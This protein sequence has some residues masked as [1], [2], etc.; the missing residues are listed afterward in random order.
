MANF[1]QH[2]LE[3]GD[4]TS[5][6]QTETFENSES[7]ATGLGVFI[8]KKE[9]DVLYWHNGAT[10]GFN[11]CIIYEPI[12]KSGIVVLTNR[13]LGAKLD[14]KIDHLAFKIFRCL[15]TKNK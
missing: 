2:L 8:N 9:T 15:Q 10:G 1:I 12:S 6:L 7:S 11:S 13:S 3:Q 14:N 4:I 5:P